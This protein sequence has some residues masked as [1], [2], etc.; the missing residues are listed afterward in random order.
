LDV[1]HFAK[2]PLFYIFFPRS[3]LTPSV[4][5]GT[6]PL[7]RPRSCV[8]PINSTFHPL[9]RHP[10]PFGLTHTLTATFLQMALTASVVNWFLGRFFCFDFGPLD[11]LSAATRFFVEVRCFAGGELRDVHF[12][13]R[14]LPPVFY[15]PL[16]PL[17]NF[18][19]FDPPF[20]SGHRVMV[21]R[22]WASLAV[23]FRVILRRTLTPFFLP[24]SRATAVF[25]TPLHFWC[26]PTFLPCPMTAF[27]NP[28]ARSDNSPL[29]RVCQ[30]FTVNVQFAF[31][32]FRLE[33]PRCALNPAGTEATVF[34]YTDN[35]RLI[36][37][38][39]FLPLF[40]TNS[41]CQSTPGSHR[42]PNKVFLPL[43]PHLVAHP[44]SG[45]P[46]LGSIW[47]RII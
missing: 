24:A 25:F 9:T 1:N 2:S 47:H 3:P 11:T 44:F 18:A 27:F 40:S 8:P 32:V 33:F 12:S 17:L 19:H 38:N 42:R 35:L 13:D 34:L 7:T 43:T 5:H 4:R 21:R 30:F 31:L 37:F 28:N 23:F 16:H 10:L 26:S 36:N 20:F 46:F 15:S 41:P 6:A 45:D 29:H 22:N 14:F 39:I